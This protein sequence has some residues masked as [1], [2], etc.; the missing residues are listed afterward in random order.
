MGFCYEVMNWFLTFYDKF[1]YMF[2]IDFTCFMIEKSTFISF[3]N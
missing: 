1:V 3:Y 2:T